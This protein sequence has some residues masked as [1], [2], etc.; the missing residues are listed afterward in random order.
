M[1]KLKP[2]RK[3]KLFFSIMYFDKD[4]L[5]EVIGVLRDK[6]G[7]VGVVSDEYAFVFTKYYDKEF[8]SGLKKRLFAF[9]KPIDRSDLADIKRFTNSLELEFSVDDNRTINIDPGYLTE[10]NV[11]LASCKELPHRMFLGDGVFGDVQLFF[12]NG[13]FVVHNN[14]FPDYKLDLVKNFFLNIRSF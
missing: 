11:V 13:S 7:E 10:H 9:K 2:V 8:G 12:K 6:F 1:A 4:L 14:T 3:A 5:D